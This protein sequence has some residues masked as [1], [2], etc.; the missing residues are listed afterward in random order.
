MNALRSLAVFAL[1]GMLASCQRAH[2]AQPPM[3]DWRTS[4]LDLNLRGMNGK[5][6]LFRCP[7]GK[8][9]PDSVAGSG[10]YTDA[11]SICAAAAHAGAIDAQQGGPVMIQ[12]LPGQGD[13]RGSTRNFIR[14]TTYPRAWGGSFAV[15][16][17]TDSGGG[18]KP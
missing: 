5:S 2:T 13:Y 18:K 3:I 16:S 9:V 4:P 17:A 1:A 6:Y 14:S 10:V 7:A 15:L 8:P 12:I 11:S